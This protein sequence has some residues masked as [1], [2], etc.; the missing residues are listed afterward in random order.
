MSIDFHSPDFKNIIQNAH[1]NPYAVFV[2]MTGVG[3]SC[4]IDVVLETLSWQ[5]NKVIFYDSNPRQSTE[6]NTLNTIPIPGFQD[7]LL[8]DTAGENFLSLYIEHASQSDMDSLF[9]TGSI[10]RRENPVT[11]GYN[12]LFL[13]LL[14]NA[15]KV[16]VCLPL[17][18]QIANPEHLLNKAKYFFDKTFE[19]KGEVIFLFTFID[20]ALYQQKKF[21]D[22][23]NHNKNLREFNTECFPKF[24]EWQSLQEQKKNKEK[25]A[26]EKSKKLTEQADNEL[27]KKYKK[28]EDI[29]L[30][31]LRYPF[32][33]LLND[34]KCNKEKCQDLAK[35]QSF[36]QNMEG[37][38][39]YNIYATDIF[40]NNKKSKPLAVNKLG[41]YKYIYM[42]YLPTF[43]DYY[44][45]MELAGNIKFEE[46]SRL[47]NYLS[48]L[49]FDDKANQN[50]KN[51]QDK[52]KEA[53]AFADI[54]SASGYLK[55][56]ATNTTKSV[57]TSLTN[58]RKNL[59]HYLLVLCLIIIATAP[60]SWFFARPLEINHNVKEE[61][62]YFVTFDKQ[63]PNPY[64]G[65]S[66]EGLQKNFAYLVKE[67]EK[68]NQSLYETKPIDGTGK[69]TP[70]ECSGLFTNRNLT[71]D[72]NYSDFVLGFYGNATNDSIYLQKMRNEVI[73]TTDEYLNGEIFKDKTEKE[74][75]KKLTKDDLTNIIKKIKNSE[76]FP[77]KEMERQDCLHTLT[78]WW[79][80][81][82]ALANQTTWSESEV[83]N[84]I[85]ITE[86]IQTRPELMESANIV[87]NINREVL[88][89]QA[90]QSVFEN[91]KAVVMPIYIDKENTSQLPTNHE[92]PSGILILDQDMKG[93]VD[94]PF[95][96][97]FHKDVCLGIKSV[98]TK[99]TNAMNDIRADDLINIDDGFCQANPDKCHKQVNW[100]QFFMMF[101]IL[102]LVFIMAYIA[103]LMY[104]KK[105]HGATP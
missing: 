42:W 81:R 82:I 40:P 13:Q 70:G 105:Q 34:I 18:S 97:E 9:S 96:K 23:P 39:G 87:D 29:E 28:E 71:E 95:H 91:K 85:K 2:G 17:D 86:K 7:L 47:A 55:S 45:T 56:Q 24:Q 78:D 76:I 98:L 21:E 30:S 48:G 5:A 103:L 73:I 26:L 77:R 72:K 14:Q 20:L 69:S 93:C 53:L 6:T 51:Y 89:L 67:Y 64:A 100:G 41:K 35:Y 31:K 52:V 19:V 92:L 11:Q 68:G 38:N 75:K 8:L 74:H 44:Q 66:T 49:N 59:L 61:L 10:N 83:D 62:A 54:T 33:S 4:L 27:E 60:I 80:A 50:I 63:T 25:E 65:L 32:E 102:T 94:P 58:H 3:K 36:I 12:D 88:L 104:R 99:S 79:S 15:T 16:Y 46:A 57:K 90:W 101:F 37:S 1:K 43:I 84:L 22:L